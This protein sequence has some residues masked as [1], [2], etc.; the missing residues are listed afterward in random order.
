MPNPKTP[1]ERVVHDICR[2]IRELHSTEDKIR[3]VSEGLRREEN[4]AEQVLELRRL[5]KKRGRVGVDR[6]RD[7]LPPSSQRSSA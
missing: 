2:A 5:K 1:A 3:I 6:E 7:P 4:V